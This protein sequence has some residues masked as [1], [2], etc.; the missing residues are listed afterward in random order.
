MDAIILCGGLGTRIRTVTNNSYPK[1][2]IKIKGKTILEW[3]LTWLRKHNIQHAILA[4]RHLAEYIEENFGNVYETQHG[5]IDISYSKEKEKLGS[6]G[7]VRLASQYVSTDLTLIMN[8]DILT[9]FNLSDMV[10]LHH[11][12]N[13]PATMA[14]AKMRSPY[15]IVEVDENSCIIRFREKPLLEHWIHA[16]VDI[17]LTDLLASFPEKGQMENTIFVELAEKKQFSAYKIPVES[18]WRS[19]DTPKDFKEAEAEWQPL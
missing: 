19:I 8:G 16:G 15:G 17:V 12:L 1:A 7:A 9:N 3:E 11:Q 6:G 4:V 5:T 18:Y 10:K 13:R 2:M 14:L